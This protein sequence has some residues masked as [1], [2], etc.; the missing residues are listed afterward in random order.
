MHFTYIREIIN[1]CWLTD[2]LTFTFLENVYHN[3]K[4]TGKALLGNEYFNTIEVKDL[5]EYLNCKNLTLDNFSGL[6]DYLKE[7]YPEVFLPKQPPT[8]R[9]LIENLV[10][11]VDQCFKGNS[12]LV[13][14]DMYEK[15]KVYLN[16]N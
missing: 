5:L 10:N 13:D 14:W 9:E 12:E 15:A 1:G 6:E 7:N 2:T 8:E 3:K 16:L 11:M 4:W